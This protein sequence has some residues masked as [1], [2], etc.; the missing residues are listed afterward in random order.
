MFEEDS[1]D[2]DEELLPDP[3]LLLLPLLEDP[4][5]DSDIVLLL[6][7]DALTPD[8]ETSWMVLDEIDF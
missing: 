1:E 8:F 7:T 3:L 5:L 2:E 4:E 6:V